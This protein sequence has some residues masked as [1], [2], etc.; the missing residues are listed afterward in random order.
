M[1]EILPLAG[2]VVV[3][4]L[5]AVL[6]FHVKKQRDNHVQLFV[7]MYGTI[8]EGRLRNLI[9]YLEDMLDV[10]DDIE[11]VGLSFFSPDDWHRI[12]DRS[13]CAEFV[14]LVGQNAL[15]M[16]ARKTLE[17]GFDCLS[18]ALELMD[19]FPGDREKPVRFGQPTDRRQW[20]KLLSESVRSFESVRRDV[21]F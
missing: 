8:L 2:I 20:R 19:G 17:H 13:L 16:R 15:G 18:Q 3:L 12:A 6:A 21:V 11:M 14:M 1:Q 4:V 7:Y 10:P 9:V 5:I